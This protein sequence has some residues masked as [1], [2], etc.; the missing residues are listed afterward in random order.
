MNH[1]DSYVMVV[2]CLQWGFIALLFVRIH[3]LRKWSRTVEELIAGVTNI[4]EEHNNRDR[5]V[6]KETDA[7]PTG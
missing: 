3:Y 1:W 6:R 5:S 4:L 7:D 2:D